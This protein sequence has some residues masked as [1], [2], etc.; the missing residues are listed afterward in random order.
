MADEYRSPL[1][2]LVVFFQSSRDKWKE[3]C[4]E[5][6]YELKLFKRRYARLHRSRDN[7]KQRCRNAEAQC[8]QLVREA[9]ERESGKGGVA[10]S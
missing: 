5:A 4:Q 7:W 6:K 10:L 1:R 9:R 3:K 2:K 8:D